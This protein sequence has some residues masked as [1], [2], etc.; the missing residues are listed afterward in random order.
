MGARTNTARGEHV[1]RNRG[2]AASPPG[3]GGFAPGAGA[4]LTLLLLAPA[5]ALLTARIRAL[6]TLESAGSPA[7]CSGLD[8]LGPVLQAGLPVVLLLIALPVALLSL[9]HRGRGWLWLGGALLA[10]AVIEVG[11]RTWA[12]ACL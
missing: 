3:D 11:L 1:T 7:G 4:L 8:T 2:T 6:V 12:P 5:A 10:T 9:G